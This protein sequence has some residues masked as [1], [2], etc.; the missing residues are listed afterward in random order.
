MESFVF[1]EMNRASREKDTS[2]IELYGP[3]G[4]ALSFII[5]AGNKKMSGFS[6]KFVVYRGLKAPLIEI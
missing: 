5:H 3:L 1:K 4:S 6:K 2:K